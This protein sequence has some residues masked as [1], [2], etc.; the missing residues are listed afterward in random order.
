[1]ITVKYTW[2]ELTHNGVLKKITI[3]SQTH[4]YRYFDDEYDSEDQAILALEQEFKDSYEYPK[5]VL[6]KLYGVES[7]K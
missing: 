7:T 5:F 3:P 6:V 2:R 4:I 1:M